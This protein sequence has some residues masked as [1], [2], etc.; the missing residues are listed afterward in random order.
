MR[1]LKDGKRFIWESERNGWKNFYLYDLSGKLI[2]PLT[3]RRRY[4]A[5]N[6]VA[7]DE[8]RNV[9]F[10]TAR[11]GDNFMKLQLHRVGLDGKDDKRLTDPAFNH[12]VDASRPTASTSSTSRRRTTC[13]RSRGCSTRTARSSPSWRRATSTK[14][15]QLGLKKVEMFTYMAAD[16]KTELHGM[17]HFR[18]TSIREEVS[19]AGQRLRRAGVSGARASASR[20]PNPLTEYG[21]LVLTLDS[22]ARARAGASVRST[23]ST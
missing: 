20:M 6:I 12:T 2:A 10:Y 13:R 5:D 23:R 1:F 15:D 11:D 14:F 4:E 18:R 17:I 16:G 19:G 9:L 21:F 3:T 22:R 8:A 7:V